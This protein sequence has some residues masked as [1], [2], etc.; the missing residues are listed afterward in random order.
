[1]WT[2]TNKI[3]AI[4]LA[5]TTLALIIDF[6]SSKSSKSS[7]RTQLVEADSAQIAKIVFFP[8]HV[9]DKQVVLL[10]KNKKWYVHT[11]GTDYPADPDKIHTILETLTSLRPTQVV[12]NNRGQWAEYGVADTNSLNILVYNNKNKTLAHLYVGKIKTTPN[13]TQYPYYGQNQNY[14]TY[15]RVK[16]DKNVYMVPQLLAIT[17]IND[18]NA[19]RDQTI[20]NVDQLDIKAVAIVENSRTL[21]LKRDGSKWSVNGQPA[22]SLQMV[23]YLRDICH[24][25]GWQFAPDSMVKDLKTLK[26]LTLEL[27]SG[28]QIV[29]KGLGDTAVN[30]IWSSQNPQSYFKAAALPSRI[31]KTQDYFLNKRADE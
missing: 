29:V 18:P 7:F 28:K 31:F 2:K 25:Q 11:N 21:S 10:R 9:R 24:L 16:G 3:L 5:I 6:I 17:F 30:V 15:V 23:H 19:Y 26:T 14:Y 4:I 22:D 12:A 1:M 8:S 20:I 13:Q 27:T